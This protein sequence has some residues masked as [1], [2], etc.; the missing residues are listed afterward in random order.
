MD[1]TTLIKS[2]IRSYEY[3]DRLYQELTLLV[4]KILGKVT[5]S[6]GDMVGVVNLF[7]E[8]NVLLDKIGKER[9]LIADEVSSWQQRKESLK[10][11]ENFNQ[12][13]QVLISIEKTISS[14]MNI[15]DQL[16]LFMEP[17]ESLQSSEV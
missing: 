9:D 5:L 15:E 10:N 8:K 17:P 12:L 2:L 1:D 13:D 7:D 11:H 14:F 16:R 3:Q 4:Q 6:R